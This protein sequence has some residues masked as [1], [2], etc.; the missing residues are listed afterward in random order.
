MKSNSITNHIAE[1][2]PLRDDFVNAMSRVAAAVNVVTTD[3]PAGRGGVTV[4]A[5]SSVSADTPAP[6]LLVC[7]HHLS[8]AVPVLLENGVFCVNVLKD[9]Q[10]QISD[11]FAGRFGDD[12]FDFG[13]WQAM[14]TGAPRLESALTAFDCTIQSRQQVGTHHVIIGAVEEVYNSDAG[15]GLIYAERHYM[16]VRPLDADIPIAA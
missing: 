8:T 13:R 5:M 7:I 11:A 1:R 3:G 15:A 4:T 2:T 14:G 10:A 16:G 9:D 6:T 12:K